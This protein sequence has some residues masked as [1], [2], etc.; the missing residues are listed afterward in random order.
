M[1]VLFRQIRRFLIVGLINTGIGLSIIWS[2]M[3]FGF[4][5]VTANVIGYIVGGTVS[6]NLNRLWTFAASN[7]DALTVGRFFLSF[8]ASYCVNFTVLSLG[9]SH[10]V[11][12][13]YILQCIAAVAYSVSFFLL[14]RYFVFNEQR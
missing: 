4:S 14:S 13:P 7:S 2:L 1:Q 11:I 5:A 8:I 10:T 3:Y 12:S 6:F 9:L